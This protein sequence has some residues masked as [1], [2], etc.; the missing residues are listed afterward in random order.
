MM[1]TARWWQEQPATTWLASVTTFTYK[2]LT[3]SGY[4]S[5]N[6]PLVLWRSFLF[7]AIAPADSLYGF[8][9]ERIFRDLFG[10]RGSSHR[11][12]SHLMSL[13]SSEPLSRLISIS[14]VGFK[15]LDLL[16]ELP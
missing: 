11:H 14:L 13:A 6:S 12:A 5:S 16:H 7:S 3:R 1:D 8:P 10:F 2:S 9:N 15:P 4:S